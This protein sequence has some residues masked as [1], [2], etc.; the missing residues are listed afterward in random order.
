M[1]IRDSHERGSKAITLIANE[2]IDS[3]QS[4][5]IETYREWCSGHGMEPVSY[6]HLST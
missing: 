2:P 3:F 1:C 5:S 4:D 6:T